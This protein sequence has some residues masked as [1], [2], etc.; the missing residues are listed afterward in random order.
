MDASVRRDVTEAAVMESLAENRVVEAY[1]DQNQH[2]I[3]EAVSL[4][5]I[6]NYAERT[7]QTD[8]P[9]MQILKDYFVNGA[10][11]GRARQYKIQDYD[12]TNKN[13]EANLMVTTPGG[14]GKEPGVYVAYRGTQTGE[15]NDNAE[16][17]YM[18]STPQQREAR[19][20]FDS[21]VEKHKR[22][23]EN[24]DVH[25]VGH[26]KGG[27]KAMFVTMTSQYGEYIDSC[28]ALDGQGYS[29]EAISYFQQDP[30]YEARRAKIT[31]VAGKY[32]FVHA[33]GIPIV[34]EENL[35]YVD[36]ELKSLKDG[37]IAPVFSMHESE[38][39]FQRDANGNFTSTLQTDADPN[40]SVLKEKEFFKEFSKLSP[41]QRKE[42][43]HP[44]MQLLWGEESP[45]GRHLNPDLL[46]VFL[47]LMNDPIHTIELLSGTLLA[48][49][50]EIATIKKILDVA[51]K[52]G[53]PIP[54]IPLPSMSTMVGLAV[55]LFGAWA[56]AKIYSEY[57]A[58]QAAAQEAMIEEMSVSEAMQNP[59]FYM[60]PHVLVQAGTSNSNGRIGSRIY[61]VQTQLRSIAKQQIPSR[62]ISIPD[63]L[64][65]GEMFDPAELARLRTIKNNISAKKKEIRAMQDDIRTS[66]EHLE[67][68][69]NTLNA[70]LSYVSDTGNEF[71][72]IEKHII[73]NVQNWSNAAM[74]KSKK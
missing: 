22:L 31:L 6:L 26:S 49:Y 60:D 42:A 74:G 15:G 11:A 50:P 34:P 21:L 18:A 53:M 45:D 2:K 56:V 59:E 9:H 71:I 44:L 41:E 58:E 38:H 40:D 32:D 4:Q 52:L 28:I 29:P 37:V 62:S 3:H 67:Q 68:I 5:E 7:G 70:V 57:T 63:L 12:R 51:K 8:D 43:A 17:M 64:G 25:V 35:Y 16:G 10:G 27:N 73:S 20:Y 47:T 33:I 66:A 48:A 36:T 69:K 65:P 54:A 24:G 13:W 61:E 46:T 72:N 23:F 19:E 30:A 1:Y 39:L 14:S 55:F